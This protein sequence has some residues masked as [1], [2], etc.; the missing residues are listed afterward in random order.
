[1]IYPDQ[2]MPVS[3][4][5]NNFSSP[6]SYTLDNSLGLAYYNSTSTTIQ[7]TFNT[8]MTFTKVT[9]YFNYTGIGGWED[10]QVIPFLME[11]GNMIYLR[12]GTAPY[13]MSAW[14]RDSSGDS[15]NES[16]TFNGATGFYNITMPASAESSTYLLFATAK[17]GS[18]YGSFKNITLNYG[19]SDSEY[20]FTHV[21][22]LMGNNHSNI[23]MKN[24]DSSTPGINASTVK[25]Q[26]DFVNASNFS[27]TQLSA[28]VE[29]TV[30]YS[31]YEAIEFTYMLDV[32]QTEQ[33]SFAVP[34]M[35]VTGVKDMAVY[36]QMFSPKRKSYTVSEIQTNNNITLKAFDPG[37]IDDD[38][39]NSDIEIA[40]YK[41]NS[42]CDVPNPATGCLLTDTA[43]MDE[44]NPFTA[45]IGGGDMSFRMGT[46]GI[47]VHYVNV[48]LLASGPP[49][50]LFDEDADAEDLTST[51]AFGKALRFGSEGPSIYDFILISLPY[52][53]TAGTGLDD[54]EQVNMSIPTFY[55][56]NWNVI[57]N[58]TE[59]GTKG[60]DLAAND[61]H[62]N[63]YQSDW[64]YLMNES[65]CV[66]NA[67]SEWF[68]VTSP[69]YIDTTNNRIWIRLPHFS[70]T[71]PSV[72]GSLVPAASSTPDTGSSSTSYSSA[73]ATD[74]DEGILRTLTVK[75]SVVFNIGGESHQ[76]IL[77]YY[78]ADSVTLL[79]YSEPLTVTLKV[80]ES[81][82]VDVNDDGILDLLVELRSL[83]INPM[84]ADIYFEDISV[85]QEAAP[86]EEE[87]VEETVDGA[88]DTP[89]ASMIDGPPEDLIEEEEGNLVGIISLLLVI[90]A[91]IG[92][93]YWFIKRK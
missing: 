63:T 38:I 73:S 64:E 58:T 91:I 77:D 36:S 88:L 25:Q 93:G 35:N 30:D 2:S 3:F 52:S 10:F 40:L 84:R 47:Q 61:T 72:Q 19:G 56:E 5:W 70:G 1:M 7:K 67:S 9:G 39:E 11:P 12:E 42:S 62:Y 86:I 81:K 6:D 18:F 22:G 32:Q 82:K 34:L 85:K 8:S 31:A 37:D 60:T 54:S 80:G 17:N 21:Y 48:D 45:V 89:T 66:T 76:I 16:D 15:L 69:C 26:F 74:I 68:N 90:L 46:G 33:S 27:L 24:P 50:A 78:S 20:N 53:E 92:I 41:S 23:S 83:N 65:A 59:N 79:I 43:N 75:D 51:D 57:W 14:M 13:N 29:L 71:S 87:T 49:D 44:F 55:D 4:D 28:H